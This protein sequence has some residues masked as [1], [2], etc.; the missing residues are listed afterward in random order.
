MLS[1]EG[2]IAAEQGRRCRMLL[3]AVVLQALI[4]ASV[5]LSKH[6][7]EQ[8]RNLSHEARSALGFLLH[9][10]GGL[11]AYCGW[12]SI[13]PATVRARLRAGLASGGRWSLPMGQSTFADA[14]RRR[15]I[16]K[17]RVR[18][19]DEEMSSGEMPAPSEEPDEPPDGRLLRS[20]KARP[21]RK[22]RKD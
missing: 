9:P 6:E 5:E 10:E 7:Q 15:R 1:E 3:S 16:I 2:T 19:F 12:L 22:R 8:Q 18:W 17:M 4:D 14:D 20:E 21:Y 11:D 13:D